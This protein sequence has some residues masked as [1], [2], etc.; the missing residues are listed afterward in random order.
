MRDSFV[1]F[2]E[3]K[4]IINKLSDEQAGKIFK[5]IFEYVSDDITPEESDVITDIVFTTFKQTIDR[6]SE[7]WEETKQKRSEAGK[8][9]AETRWADGKNGKNGNAITDDGKNGNAIFAN[10]TDDGKMAKM[11]VSVSVSDPVPVS[12]PVSV[13]VV[14]EEKEKEEAAETA[15]A[16][17]LHNV[18]PVASE[19]ELQQIQDYENDLPSDLVIYALKIA[20]EQRKTSLSY[21]KAILRDWRARGIVCLKQAME[22]RLQRQNKEP[23]ASSN[24][25]ISDTNMSQYGDL[26][27]YYCNL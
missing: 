8:K 27:Q 14:E 20:V 1:L 18:N 2:T 26:S 3:Q 15:T 6:N 23:T 22:E 9:G 4:E 11:A 19:Y 7:K 17:Y 12:V 25:F 24:R 5:A 13:N 10:S 16:F 21:I